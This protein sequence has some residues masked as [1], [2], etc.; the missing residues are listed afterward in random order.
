MATSQRILTGD[1]T[2][3]TVVGSDHYL[4]RPVERYLEFLRATGC[5]PNTIKAYAR[6]LALWWTF[7]EDRAQSWETV[8][9]ADVGS[10]AQE[11]RQGRGRAPVGESTVALR[12]RSVLSFYRFHAHDGVTVA[13]GLYENTRTRQ[14]GYLPFLEHIARRDGR[15]RSI[16]RVRVAKREVPI[17]TPLQGDYRNFGV[18]GP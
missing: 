7:L 1:S 14:R 11:V 8:G 13:D 2:T 12:V 4:V 18:S 6:G 3:W 16:V 15:R 10:F 9:V 17:V 5:S